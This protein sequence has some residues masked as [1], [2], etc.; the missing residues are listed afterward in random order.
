M[1]TPTRAHDARDEQL[2]EIADRTVLAP[3]RSSTIAINQDCDCTDRRRAGDIFLLIADEP[4]MIGCHVEFSGQ[5]SKPGRVWF[6]E[7]DFNRGE[8]LVDQRFQSGRREIAPDIGLR[9]AVRNVGEGA[10]ADALCMQRSNDFDSLRLG[11]D[12]LLE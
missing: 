6:S 4:Q 7:S 5:F 9:H 12:S 11:L 10:D 2:G 1:R 3:V 8:N